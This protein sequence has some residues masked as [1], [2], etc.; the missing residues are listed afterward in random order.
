MII[1]MYRRRRRKNFAGDLLPE[2]ENREL[3][4]EEV[5][6]LNKIHHRF[7]KQQIESFIEE[8]MKD[9]VMETGTMAP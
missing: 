5:L 9:G 4:K 6:Q 7:T 1:P 3:S 2:E 8:H